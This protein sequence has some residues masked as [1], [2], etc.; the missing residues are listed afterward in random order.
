ML[1]AVGFGRALAE[2]ILPYSASQEAFV[3]ARRHELELRNSWNSPEVS[4]DIVQKA[5]DQLGERAWTRRTIVLPLGV[6]H[7][8]LSALLFA[9]ALRALRGSAW[10]HG[11]WQLACAASVPYTLVAA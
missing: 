9:G 3:S 2:Q 11:A 4:S 5:G 7:L 6:A 10:G 8:V 1:G